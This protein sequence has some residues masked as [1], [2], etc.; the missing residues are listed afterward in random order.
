MGCTHG[1]WYMDLDGRLVK[2]EPFL[3]N[4]FLTFCRFYL[5]FKVQAGVRVKNRSN[6][7]EGRGSCLSICVIK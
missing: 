4:C 6:M 5:L 7:L 1:I 2:K 3:V